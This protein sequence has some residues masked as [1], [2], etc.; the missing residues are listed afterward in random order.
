MLG[1][2]IVTGYVFKFLI[3]FIAPALDSGFPEAPS[4]LNKIVQGWLIIPQNYELVGNVIAI[5]AV[6]ALLACILL[7]ERPGWHYALLGLSV[8]MFTF[9]W[10]TRFSVEPAATRILIVGVT[11]VVLMV[12]RPQGILG[13]AEVKVI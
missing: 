9:A 8:Y 12:L 1:G 10:E 3:S 6:F 5:L 13:K 4:V 2:T 11:L 7:R